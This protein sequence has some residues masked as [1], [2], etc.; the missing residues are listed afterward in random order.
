M[1][2]MR[3]VNFPGGNAYVGLEG[4]CVRL[5]LNGWH[6]GTPALLTPVEARAISQALDEYA[7]AA[8]QQAA[9]I[10]VARVHDVEVL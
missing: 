10:L 2:G 4:S 5:V 8:E 1:M 7:V 6:H 9:S 3:C